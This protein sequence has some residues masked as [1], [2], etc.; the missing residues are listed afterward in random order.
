MTPAACAGSPGACASDRR[1]PNPAAFRAATAALR[2]ARTLPHSL[3]WHNREA[4]RGRSCPGQPARSPVLLSLSL[5][6]GPSPGL[7]AP[8]LPQAGP[9]HGPGAPA[10][11]T[12]ARRCASEQPARPPRPGRGRQTLRGRRAGDCGPRGRPGGQVG[13][14]GAAARRARLPQ[15]GLGPATA[16][17]RAPR[18]AESAPPAPAAP[19]SAGRTPTVRR[20]ARPAPLEVRARPPRGS[21]RA[22]WARS[23][24]AWPR[25]TQGRVPSDSRVGAGWRHFLK[26]LRSRLRTQPGLSTAAAP[27]AVGRAPSPPGK[28]SS[29]FLPDAP[30]L[31]RRPSGPLGEAPLQPGSSAACPWP[32]PP[33]TS[34]PSWCE[35]GA[36]GLCAGLC[37]R[38]SGCACCGRVGLCAPRAFSESAPPGCGPPGSGPAKE[39]PEA[40]A[41]NW[42]AAAL[43]RPSLQARGPLSAPRAAPETSERLLRG[44]GQPGLSS[45]SAPPLPGGEGCPGP[46]SAQD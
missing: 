42:R 14:A 45:P 13:A 26:K 10:A 23:C 16:K 24:P 21:V 8:S 18:G 37:A 17:R 38:C 6:L 28:S 32:R 30:G 43:S 22:A 40:G 25:S 20:G 44:G 4:R 36:A 5:R 15:P 9:C 41:R 34:D 2:P 7:R 11:R 31:R 39:G 19:S 27:A 35:E 12:A 46:E 1:V 33:V 3:A 29:R